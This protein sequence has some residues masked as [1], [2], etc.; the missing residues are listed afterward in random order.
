MKLCSAG[1]SLGTIISFSGVFMS[2]IELKDIN[3][4][5]GPSEERVI[6]SLSLSIERGECILLEG[7]NGSGKSTL[8][9][10][11]NGLSLPDSGTYYFDSRLIDNKYLKSERDAKVFHKEI[12]YLFQNPDIMLFCASVYD[13]IGF[14][15]RQMGLDDVEVDKRVRDL[16]KTFDIEKLADKAPYHL[17]GGQKKKIAFAAVMALNPKAYILDEPFAGLDRE[18]CEMI[19]RLIKN[20]KLMG[21]TIIIA[22]HDES[23]I[24]ELADR[25]LNIVELMQ[26]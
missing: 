21:K 23:D 5:Y 22:S 2:I 12:G 1:A 24:G 19:G 8:F 18:S 10:I 14:G 11:L 25:R 26:D 6:K 7:P 17:S 16:L 4:S 20:L 3:F 13:E 15:P 9:R